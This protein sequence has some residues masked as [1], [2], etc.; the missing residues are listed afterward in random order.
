[1]TATFS[2]KKARLFSS[3]PAWF[4]TSEVERHPLTFIVMLVIFVLFFLPYTMPGNTYASLGAYGAL[5]VIPVTG[6]SFLWERKG[7]FISTLLVV[8]GF[9]CVNCFDIGFHWPFNLV[10][11]WLLGAV[12]LLFF[13]MVTGQ[14]RRTGQQLKAAHVKSKQTEV[15]LARAYEQ[16][17]ELNTLKDQ[18][19]FNVSHELRTPLTQVY[20][21]LQLLEAYDETLTSERRAAFLGR[22][23][24]GCEE[25]LLLITNLLDAACVERA[26]SQRN[27]CCL[28]P[29]MNFL[30]SLI[31]ERVI[32][33]TWI[34]PRICWFMP[35]P[36]MCARSC[37][38]CFPMLSSM[39]HSILL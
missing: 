8:F 23:T 30:T 20:G 35:I 12:G 15:Q 7:G 1:M 33:C 6:A 26:M 10:C 36:S 39:L 11:T 5:S 4:K 2:L 34:L 29:C 37:A 22:T 16:Q 9:A 19:L 27:W 31:C 24:Q 32:L 21:Y 38:I 17:V 13:G 25:L 28:T 14:L 3:L 18:F